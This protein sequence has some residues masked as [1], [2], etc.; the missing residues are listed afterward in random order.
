[1]AVP[2]GMGAGRHCG[3]DRARGPAR[4]QIGF[5]YDFEAFF[6]EGQPETTF[7]Q[8]RGLH[9]D[10]DFI[11]VGLKGENGVFDRDFLQAT[12]DLASDTVGASPASSTP[13]T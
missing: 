1:M 5:N 13:P 4:H 9:T 12:R 10:N 6:P 8:F 2:F 3:P 11:L 7:Y